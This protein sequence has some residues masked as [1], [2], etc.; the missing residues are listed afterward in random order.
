M[1]FIDEYKS[2]PKPA[3]NYFYF[4]TI[5]IV[6][7][8]LLLVNTLKSGDVLQYASTGILFLL[9]WAFKIFVKNSTTKRCEELGYEVI[10]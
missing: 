7:L 6:G 5:S 4:L 8:F 10:N 2:W 3:R 1:G 9:W